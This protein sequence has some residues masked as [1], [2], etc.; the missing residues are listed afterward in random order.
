MVLPEMLLQPVRTP[1]VHMHYA[2]SGSEPRLIGWAADEWLKRFD[3][4]PDD[5]IAYK[6]KL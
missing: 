3:V 5:L 4:S 1:E 6:A 2:S